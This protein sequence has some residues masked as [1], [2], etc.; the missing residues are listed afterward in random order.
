MSIFGWLQI[1]GV[2]K[3]AND[4]GVKH[5]QP[6]AC[7]V[8]VLNTRLVLL[9]KPRR[10]RGENYVSRYFHSDLHMLTFQLWICQVSLLAFLQKGELR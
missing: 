4:N 7:T 2:R 8:P 1:G 3:Q 10:W 9:R 5:F 6:D